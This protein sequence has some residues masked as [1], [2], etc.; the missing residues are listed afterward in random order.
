MEIT[1]KSQP[2]FEVVEETE[3]SFSTTFFLFL[4]SF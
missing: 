3:M 1:Q 2:L 4:L